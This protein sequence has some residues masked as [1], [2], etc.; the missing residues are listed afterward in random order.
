MPVAFLP[1]PKNKLYTRRQLSRIFII[2]TLR[3]SLQIE[4]ICQLLS[5]INGHLTD[6]SDDT[7][8]D[9]AL[10]MYLVRLCAGAELGQE[11]SPA[12]LLGDYS[13]PFPGAK[14][15]VAKVLSIMVTAY[16]ASRLRKRAEDMILD[17]DI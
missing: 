8:D 4:R 15:R 11:L 2:N 10:Y 14:E 12:E 3:G 6:E 13:E 5:Y 7:I 9:T 1:P 16:G 17:L